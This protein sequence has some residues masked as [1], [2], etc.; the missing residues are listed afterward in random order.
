MLI[1]NCPRRR[2]RRRGAFTLLEILVTTAL[3]GLLAGVLTIGA[4]ALLNSRNAS[5]KKILLESINASRRAA[6]LNH[7]DVTL[8]FNPETR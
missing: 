2:P 3:I 6:L 5:P 7:T 4:S 8:A 1:A